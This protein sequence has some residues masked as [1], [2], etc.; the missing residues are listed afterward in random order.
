MRPGSSPSS[1]TSRHL[2][3]CSPSTLVPF[4]QEKTKVLP[5]LGRHAVLSE[6]ALPQ[7]FTATA[8][9]AW[10]HG[11][12]VPAS[13]RPPDHRRPGPTRYSPPD[14]C[15]VCHP[16]HFS[17]GVL[18]Y[19]TAYLCR[20]CPHRTKSGGLWEGRERICFLPHCIP[21]AQP[22]AW[23]TGLIVMFLEW[24]G[25]WWKNCIIHQQLKSDRN[26]FVS[27]LPNATKA[28][29]FTWTRQGCAWGFRD[30][31]SACSE[32]HSGL[33]RKPAGVGL[34]S[35]HT[36]AVSPDILVPGRARVS[37][38]M[39][40]CPSSPPLACAPWFCRRAVGQCFSLFWWVCV[41]KRS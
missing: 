40:R 20:A 6:E 34:Y 38:W 14:T 8:L 19:L 35:E 1:H 2:V 37:L 39:K 32:P 7:F 4:R 25:G 29:S 30:L 26:H 12:T 16:Q 17:G 27:N 21:S 22:S 28:K 15:L 11:L 41:S 24:M 5:A 10:S 36:D 23:H 18:R 13:F 3:H 33:S 31:G 9:C